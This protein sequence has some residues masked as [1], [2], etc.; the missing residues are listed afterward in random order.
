[1][2]G[3]IVA[4]DHPQTLYVDHT[5]RGATYT[6]IYLPMFAILMV[7]LAKLPIGPSAFLW[8]AL[9]VAW[10]V[11]IGVAAGHRPFPVSN[12]IAAVHSSPFSLFL[13]MAFTMEN[14]F[15]GQVHALLLWLMTCAWRLFAV[16][17]RGGGGKRVGHCRGDQ[18]DP[19][20][21]RPLFPAPS[22]V[23]GTRGVRR[24]LCVAR[25]GAPVTRVRPHAR[26]R[27]APGVLGD[28]QIQPYF[29]AES[30]ARGA[31]GIYHRTAVRKT[32]HDQDL[33]ALLQRHFTARQRPE[34]RG[35]GLHV[36]EPRGS[37]RQ[38]PSGRVCS[39]DLQPSLESRR[40]S[41]SAVPGTMLDAVTAI[42]IQCA[43]F[44]VMSLLLAPRNRLCYMT[45]FL[46][47]SVCRGAVAGLAP[48]RPGHHPPSVVDHRRHVRPVVV[49]GSAR[50]SGAVG[51]VLRHTVDLGGVADVVRICESGGHKGR[52]YPNPTS[53]IIM[54]AKPTMTPIVARSTW[55]LACDSGINSSATT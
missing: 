54:T 1:M 38:P 14:M 43:V 24:G 21:L 18:A 33:G 8:Y 40:S 55:P 4:S 34:R 5:A 45:V 6:Y 30:G 23:E 27:T 22:R 31:L 47:R 12:G 17:P 16:R 20:C 25:G 3:Q 49:D 52:P 19:G 10:T 35:Q 50:A 44:T 32:L 15:L 51:R 9:S 29:A 53:S 46:I 26:Y 37:G 39:S 48:R 7:P 2:A 36:G 42:D 13:T 41:C 11:H 28:P